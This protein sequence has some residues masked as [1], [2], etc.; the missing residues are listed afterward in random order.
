MSIK[1]KVSK[2]KR[3]Q[4]TRERYYEQINSIDAAEDRESF[5]ADFYARAVS[6]NNGALRDIVVSD[7]A[8]YWGM[9]QDETGEV[10]ERRA[11][12]RAV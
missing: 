7:A 2:P 11:A 6:E 4:T 5:Y 8:F 10:L 3:A 9:F 12:E 1:R